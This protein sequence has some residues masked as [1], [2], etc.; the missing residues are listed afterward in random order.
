MIPKDQWSDVWR[1]FASRHRGWLARVL[2]LRDGDAANGGRAL[3]VDAPCGRSSWRRRGREAHIRIL[4]GEDDR[5]IAQP[6]LHPR[7]LMLEHRLDGSEAGLRIEDAEGA[8]T[9]VRF[10]VIAAPETLDG[11]APAER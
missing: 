6:V 4:V 3:A 1:G 9:L 8:R 7:A 11:L 5:H 2:V 10:R